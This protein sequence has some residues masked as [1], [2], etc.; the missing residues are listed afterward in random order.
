MAPKQGEVN[1]ADALR[2]LDGL[3]TRNGVQL[4]ALI[5]LK[6]AHNAAQFPDR[7]ALQQIDADIKREEGGKTEGSFFIAA[8]VSMLL[9]EHKQ[10]REIG[11]AS[12]R[13]RV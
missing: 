5:C 6:Q 1:L 10:A 12:C 9:D 13:E 2:E 7:E 4:P 11:R 3:R 8:Q